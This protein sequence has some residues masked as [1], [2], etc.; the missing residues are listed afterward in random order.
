MRHRCLAGLPRT[1]LRFKNWFLPC[2]TN[3]LVNTRPGRRFARAALK[4]CGS[5]GYRD[6]ATSPT[7]IFLNAKLVACHTSTPWK[8]RQ[9][10]RRFGRNRDYDCAF[11]SNASAQN[12][13]LA[14]KRGGL[15]RI[16]PSCLTTSLSHTWVGV[17]YG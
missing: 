6:Q 5:V 1:T 3:P 9:H 8:L 2:V 11:G 4:S 10:K 7:F 16:S 13:Y 15:Q 12:C 17:Q 14:R